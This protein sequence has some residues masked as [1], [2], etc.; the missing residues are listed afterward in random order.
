MNKRKF[1]LYI[2]IFF[3]IIFTCK[4]S[5]GYLFLAPFGVS[6]LIDYSDFA[7]RYRSTRIEGAFGYYDQLRV[8]KFTQKSTA[9]DNVISPCL[10]ILSEDTIPSIKP[11]E[12][13]LDRDLR[14]EEI[15]AAD[16]FREKLKPHFGKA[17]RGND[18][19]DISYMIILDYFFFLVNLVSNHYIDGTNA[20]KNIHE[21]KVQN[22]LDYLKKDAEPVT[23]KSAPEVI[24]IL[25]RNILAANKYDNARELNESPLVIASD[26]REKLTQ[27]ILAIGNKGTLDLFIDNLGPEFSSV[28]QFVDYLIENNIVGSVRM[29]IKAAPHN[30]SDVWGTENDPLEAE[31]SK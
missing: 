15:R 9:N 3:I 1:K 18:A 11:P 4:Y 10:G 16:I 22:G 31:R 2:S 29:H 26:Q 14:G 23:D 5:I 24:S 30:I 13:Y 19:P 20:H 17:W 7:V 28:L 25:L 6:N 21:E 8:V 12:E 27:A